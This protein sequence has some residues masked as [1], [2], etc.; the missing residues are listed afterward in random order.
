MFKYRYIA[1]GVQVYWNTGHHISCVRGMRE[2]GFSGIIVEF[3]RVSVCPSSV[4]MVWSVSLHA[5][6]LSPHRIHECVWNRCGTGGGEGWEFATYSCE[7]PSKPTQHYTTQHKTELYFFVPAIVDIRGRNG[8]RNIALRTLCRQQSACTC[9]HN[10]KYDTCCR[11]VNPVNIIQ[12]SSCFLT[13]WVK[14]Q[15]VN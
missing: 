8:M 1:L 4:G 6:P 7:R 13:F 3:V 15:A 2:G 9:S 10:V 14:S 12:L 5:P 11:R